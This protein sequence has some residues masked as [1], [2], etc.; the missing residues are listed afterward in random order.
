MSEQTS[1]SDSSH[2]F[3]RI[4]RFVLED[5]WH[6]DL[7]PRSVTASALRLL[8]MVVMI[9]RGFVQDELLLR[10]SALTYVTALAVMPLLVVMVALMQQLL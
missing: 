8:Q 3:A 2:F 6:V 4:Q 1:G 10:A 5:L 7:R 9:A